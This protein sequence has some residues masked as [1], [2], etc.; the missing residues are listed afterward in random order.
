MQLTASGLKHFFSVEFGERH[1]S[2]DFAETT[3]AIPN[4]NEISRPASH[5]KARLN[6]VECSDRAKEQYYRRNQ[7]NSR[8]LSLPAPGLVPAMSTN[9]RTVSASGCCRRRGHDAFPMRWLT[10]TSANASDFACSW[11]IIARSDQNP[12]AAFRSPRGETR[13]SAAQS[14]KRGLSRKPVVKCTRQT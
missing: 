4:K 13:R 2:R 12:K 10:Q 5:C 1:M 7:L 14:T 3:S 8:A 11:S 6:L 9:A